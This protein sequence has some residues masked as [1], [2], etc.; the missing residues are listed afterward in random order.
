VKGKSCDTFA[1]LGPELVPADEVDPPKLRLWL[2]VNGQTMQDSNTSDLI[3]GVPFL[4]SYISQFMT[5]LPGDVISPGTPSGV[6]LGFKP[7]RYLKSGDVVVSGIDA[8]GEGRQRIMACADHPQERR[9]MAD[10]G[11]GL[12][13]QTG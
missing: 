8:L 13:P 1:P 3:F 9:S 10:P 2:K 5:L 12:K 11:G 4:I 6:G 7:P